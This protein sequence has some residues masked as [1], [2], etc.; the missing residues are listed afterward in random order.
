MR[1]VRQVFEFIPIEKQIAHAVAESQVAATM[2][3]R[4][5]ANID[6]IAM[7]TDVELESDE[8]AESDE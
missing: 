8:E 3:E 5:S 1:G 4:N 7:M 2:A 6:Y